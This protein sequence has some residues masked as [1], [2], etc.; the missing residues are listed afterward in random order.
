MIGFLRS[1]PMILAVSSC[2]TI[3]A[4]C[5]EGPGNLA[6]TE[7]TV[8]LDGKPLDNIHVEFWPETTGPRSMATTDAQGRF[9][10]MTDDGKHAGAAIGT[11]RVVLKD[12]VL[13]GD[14]FLG[15]AGE[16]VDLSQGKKARIAGTYSDPEKTPLK[17]EVKAGE[18]NEFQLEVTK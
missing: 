6:E 16:D 17:K 3:L 11:N 15:R 5:G 10:L 7:G 4:G 18:K 13:Y 9:K 2:F 14:K 8:V 1:V 12:M